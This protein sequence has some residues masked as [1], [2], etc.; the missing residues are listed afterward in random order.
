M[1]IR[2]NLFSLLKSPLR[3]FPSVCVSTSQ[4]LLFVISKAKKKK[5]IVSFLGVTLSF[6]QSETI[7]T[8]VNLKSHRKIKV[9]AVC[10]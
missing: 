10:S 8:V 4:A 6:Q 2:L 1:H 9:H 5:E 3:S 7:R